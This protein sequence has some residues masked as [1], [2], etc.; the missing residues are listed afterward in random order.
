MK[1]LI[2]IFALTLSV[3]S[4]ASIWTCSGKTEGV[5]VNLVVERDDQTQLA[6]NVS[7]Q[8]SGAITAEHAKSEPSIQGIQ[9]LEGSDGSAEVLV[10]MFNDTSNYAQAVLVNYQGSDIA[11]LRWGKDEQAQDLEA[12][13][14]A[15]AC[16]ITPSAL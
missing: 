3:S 8:L 9:L 16:V 4:Q 12:S 15:L 10:M 2:T 1:A 13:D 7:L 11:L 14:P 6:N 5:S